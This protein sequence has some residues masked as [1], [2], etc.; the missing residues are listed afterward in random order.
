MLL[1]DYVISKEVKSLGGLFF[2]FMHYL[3]TGPMFDLK[4]LMFFSFNIEFHDIV[5]L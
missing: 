4:N 5:L 1:D 2:N 3:Q